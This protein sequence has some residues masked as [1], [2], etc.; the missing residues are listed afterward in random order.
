MKKFLFLL[1]AMPIQSWSMHSNT[2]RMP[3]HGNAQSVIEIDS[4]S[5]ASVEEVTTHQQ[6]LLAKVIENTI[7]PR[8][9]RI[10]DNIRFLNTRIAPLKGCIANNVM[11]P[12]TTWF[13]V[14][15]YLNQDAK[16][17]KFTCPSCTK[18]FTSAGLAAGCFLK[19]FD[20]NIFACPNCG[21]YNDTLDFFYAHKRT[22]SQMTCSAPSTPLT[23]H[24]VNNGASRAKNLVD[25]KVAEIDCCGLSLGSWARGLNHVALAH[26]RAQTIFTC[27]K[28]SKF[29]DSAQNALACVIKHD[30]A[31]IFTCP[32]CMVDCV[33]HDAFLKHVCPLI[34][35]EIKS[36]PIH[37]TV[38]NDPYNESVATNSPQSSPMTDVYQYYNSPMP[39]TPLTAMLYNNINTP[40]SGY[41]SSSISNQSSV[42][43]DGVD[44]QEPVAEDNQEASLVFDT[45][46][47]VEDNVKI[48]RNII[49]K[50]ISDNRYNCC[51]HHGLNW[52]LFCEHVR[53]A[54]CPEYNKVQCP[55][56]N[57]LLPSYNYGYHHIATHTHK[58]LFSCPI[59]CINKKSSKQRLA[60]QRESAD[61]LIA[62][63]KS[64][65]KKK[66]NLPSTTQFICPFCKKNE[67]STKSSFERHVDSCTA[68]R[69]LGFEQDDVQMHDQDTP[70]F[71][72]IHT[73]EHAFDL[74]NESTMA[75]NFQR[76]TNPVY[77]YLELHDSGQDFF[78]YYSSPDVDMPADQ[79]NHNP[80]AP[81]TYQENNTNAVSITDRVIDAH[82]NNLQSATPKVTGAANNSSAKKD[83][84]KELKI[85]SY[86][87]VQKRKYTRRGII[88][89]PAKQPVVYEQHTFDAQGSWDYNLGIF[90]KLIAARLASKSFACCELK[91]LTWE[92][93]CA[94]QKEKHK[95][96]I[97]GTSKVVCT[98]CDK[99]N[100][101]ASFV[102]EH[103]VTHQYPSLFKCPVCAHD[104][105]SVLFKYKENLLKHFRKCFAD[106]YP[107]ANNDFEVEHN[108]ENNAAEQEQSVSVNEQ[109]NAGF[110]AIT[111]QHHYSSTQTNIQTISNPLFNYS[112]QAHHELDDVLADSEYNRSSQL[113]N[114]AIGEIEHNFLESNNHMTGITT[115]NNNMHHYAA[116]NSLGATFV[117]HSPHQH[118]LQPVAHQQNSKKR[119]AGQIV[120]TQFQ[121]KKKKLRGGAE[122]T[123]IEHPVV[124]E[125]H[126]FDKDG[127]WNHNRAVLHK[128]LAAR[129]AANT[130]SCCELKDL[131]WENFCIHQKDKHRKHIDGSHRAVCKDC[132]KSFSQEAWTHDHSA[133]HQYPNLFECPLC[134]GN[135]STRNYDNKE[136][137]AK[138]FKSCLKKNLN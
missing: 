77:G 131:S 35:S 81:Q 14:I 111:N 41:T 72:S 50:R 66:Y 49:K 64:C 126:T 82:N 74:E 107:S 133:T 119:K 53:K 101:F 103:T 17:N 19:H 87:H 27:S 94:H 9:A 6:P 58:S 136:S 75:T 60:D 89:G 52:E 130:Y 16:N 42:A 116:S 84:A 108:S 46:K 70:E 65:F 29:Y 61:S 59:G 96:L 98:V 99:S 122:N 12:F 90:N 15:N 112:D 69:Q 92:E 1:V 54:H 5:E 24:T 95:K 33:L 134:K 78:N 88:S 26:K 11:Q 105:K 3:A 68:K 25:Q 21:S 97:D 31:S 36:E 13:G 104:D 109:Y 37:N 85:I 10:N 127:D 102:H 117:E 128:L 62:H 93:F 30:D 32:N 123:R 56:C 34:K 91:N 124:I 129:H 39:L 51:E 115:P 100:R 86:T 132:G 106:K 57:K 125:D 63:F 79:L 23:S 73:P 2:N 18:H 114:A 113:F 8:G 137:L 135:A 4:D 43:S 83:T 20:Q 22:C 118:E 55:Q 45:T 38:H 110:E 76:M 40:D 44:A 28:C 71:G 120:I 138:H 7:T 80:F 121:G 47:S 48:L 67:F